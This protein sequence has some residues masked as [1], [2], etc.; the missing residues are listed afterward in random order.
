[1][2]LLLAKNIPGIGCSLQMKNMV[3]MPTGN[4]LF[5]N[6]LFSQAEEALKKKKKEQKYNQHNLNLL[7]N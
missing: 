5:P 3:N 1:V 4:W 2:N 7:P 6:C